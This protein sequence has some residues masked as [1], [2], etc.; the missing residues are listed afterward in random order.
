[1]LRKIHWPSPALV[2]AMV[3]L[4][5]ALGGTA[6]AAGVP[7][8]EIGST[9]GGSLTGTYPNPTI[10]DGAIGS[11]QVADGS[12]RSE[13]IA[14]FK[15]TITA[16]LGPIDP[17]GCPGIGRALPGLETTDYAIVLP[18]D[19]LPFRFPSALIVQPG[20]AADSGSVFV[21]GTICNISQETI[22]PPATTFRYLVI[23]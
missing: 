14:L 17:G 8:V 16:D 22:D 21:T 3:A 1:M 10:A 12:L 2:V 6:V 13:D 20:I 4:L 18:T 15:G 19:P 11:A 23:R 9:A 7:F 5:V